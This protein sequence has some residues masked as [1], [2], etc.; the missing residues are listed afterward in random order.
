[1]EQKTIYT[2]VKFKKADSNGDIILYLKFENENLSDVSE[3][4]YRHYGH[5]EIVSITLKVSLLYGT[6]ESQYELKEID[7]ET[8]ILR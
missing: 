7:N 4:I 2:C 6:T 1:M 3:A 5:D 8:E